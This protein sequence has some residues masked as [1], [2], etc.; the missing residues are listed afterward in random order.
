MAALEAPT[1]TVTLIGGRDGGRV[2]LAC[3]GERSTYNLGVDP[4]LWGFAPQALSS[5]SLGEVP[6]EVFTG[7]R[8][9]ASLLPCPITV[10][11]ASTDD[12]DAALRYLNT[13][14]A[15][16]EP[17]KIR[18]ASTGIT[19]EI[20]AYY[21]T[22]LEGLPV[23]DHRSKT[24]TVPL[25]LKAMQPFWRDVESDDPSVTGV[26]ANAVSGG[27]NAEDIVCGSDIADTWPEFTITGPIENVQIMNLERGRLIRITEVLDVNDVLTIV[28]DPLARGV[29]F[30][31]V[32][33]YASLDAR[34]TM[35]SLKP[36]LNRVV[37]RGSD[38]T[39][40]GNPGDYTITWSP[41]FG[42]C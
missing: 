25:V 38:L 41:R 40:G 3:A 8:A 31:G 21:Y 30:N 2:V 28:T 22:G 36:G 27:S 20:T 37:L 4:G 9:T 24:A 12:L 7:A 32:R 34:S 39:A 33:S 10:V 18:V 16:E 13:L 14:L 26:F 6:G 1:R 35:W 23:R 5:I 42:S 11:S 29:W 15:P 19:R 17:V